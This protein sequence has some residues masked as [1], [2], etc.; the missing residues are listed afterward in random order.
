MKQF[1]SRF[2]VM[3]LTFAFGLAVVPF[4]NDLYEKWSEIPVDLPE[5]E[6]EIPIV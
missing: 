3:L 2:R 5:V 6:S 4:S 1:Y